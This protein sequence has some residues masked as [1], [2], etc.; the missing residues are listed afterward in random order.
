MGR[1]GPKIG[2]TRLDLLE[3]TTGRILTVDKGADLLLREAVE[4]GGV[5]LFLLNHLCR[6][7]ISR[8]RLPCKYELDGGDD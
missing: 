5:V 3:N 7:T 6:E 4:G 1:A 8:A 2:G